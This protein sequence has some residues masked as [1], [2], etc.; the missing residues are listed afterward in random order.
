MT[1]KEFRKLHEKFTPALYHFAKQLTEDPVES[2]DLVQETVLKAFRSRDSFRKDSSYKSWVFTILKNT[3]INKYHKRRRRGVVH[4]PVEELAYAIDRK[5][6]ARNKGYSNLRVQEIRSNIEELSY[7]SRMP[8]L[9]HAEGYQYNEIAETLDI[10]IGTV[11]SRISFARQKLREKLK[12][13]AIA[14]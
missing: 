5:G 12:E 6:L 4:Q 13:T 1:R 14:S 8:L 11:K 9:M 2:E 3:F 7:K 10:P